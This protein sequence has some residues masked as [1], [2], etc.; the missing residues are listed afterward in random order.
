MKHRSEIHR[1]T[2]GVGGL[3]KTGLLHASRFGHGR[4][5]AVSRP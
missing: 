2:P 5:F 4:V 1:V 3:A